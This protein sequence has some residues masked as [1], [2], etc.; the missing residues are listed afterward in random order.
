MPGLAFRQLATSRNAF[1]I[2]PARTE[3]Q[4]EPCYIELICGCQVTDCCRGQPC[5]MKTR[6][7]FDTFMFDCTPANLRLLYQYVSGKSLRGVF[8]G[9]LV[10]TPHLREKCRCCRRTPLA[11]FLEAVQAEIVKVCRDFRS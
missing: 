7:L 4:P 1:T 11:E 8:D 5:A 2:G 9:N 10:S 6:I 3:S